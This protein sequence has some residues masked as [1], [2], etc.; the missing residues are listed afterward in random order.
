L[1]GKLDEAADLCRAALRIRPGSGPAEYG[2]GQIVLAQRNYREAVEL[3]SQALRDEP[4]LVD[5]YLFRGIAFFNLQKLDQALLSLERF[6]RLRPNDR[7]VRFFLAGTYNAQGNYS[8][9]AGY[10]LAQ[11]EITPERT[12]LWYFLGE[13]LLNIALGVQAN[14]FNGP[15][16]KYSELMLFGQEEAE[17]GDVKVAERDFREAIKSDPASPEAYVNLGNLLLGEGKHAQAKVQFQEALQRALQNCRAL[18]GLGDVELALGDI[19]ASIA[20][21]AKVAGAKEACLEEPVPVNLGLSAAEFGAR[22]KSLSEYAASAKWKLAATFELS[23][24]K[25]YDLGAGGLV[26]AEAVNR[27][28]GGDASKRAGEAQPC[29]SAIPRREWLSSPGVNLFLANCLENR[30]DFRGAMKALN[31]AEPRLNGDLDIA[32]WIFRLYMRLA[33]RVLVEFANRS[34]DS[35][36]L[37]EMQAESLELQGR[38]ADA[39]KEYRKAIASSGSDPN[40]LIDFGRFKCKRNELDDAV[41]ILK[42]ALA[43]APYNAKANDSM[44]EALFMKGD[45]ATA[46]PHLQNAIS[47][48]PGNEDGRIRLAQSLARLDRIKEAILTLEAAPN[49]GDGRIHYILA[50]YYRR[51]GRDEEMQQALAFFETRQ[52]ALK[53]QSVKQPN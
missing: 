18:E 28:V 7:E 23:R 30:G 48:N 51:Q 36:L 15:R 6:Y 33:Q 32:Y 4:S 44:G 21:Y 11:L 40:P 9:A 13:C 45:Y 19:P 29:H 53:T 31:A 49:D 37:S 16:G 5:A 42:E 17:K 2:L 22:L 25:G 26:A 43:L 20:Q 50:G 24:L 38:D 34:P 52:K 47:A 27:Q 1:A 12:E 8:K 10:Y 39:E 14:F 41:A 46:I 3:F 35:Y